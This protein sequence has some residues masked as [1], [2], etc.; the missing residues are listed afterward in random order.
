MHFRHQTRLEWFWTIV[1]ALILAAIAIPSLCLL[2]LND[3]PVRNSNFAVTF[4][5]VAH[6]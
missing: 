1:P 5:A 2:Y 6:Q 3:R 4:K